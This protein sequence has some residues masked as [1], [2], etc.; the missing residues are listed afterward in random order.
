MATTEMRIPTIPM[1]SAPPEIPAKAV[2]FLGD[3]Y[4]TRAEAVAMLKGWEKRFQ[5]K[6]KEAE[7]VDGFRG[8]TDQAEACATVL[9]LVSKHDPAKAEGPL[10]L[11]AL[12]EKERE[13][14]QQA[15]E[16]D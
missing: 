8:A 13:A 2:A 1:E 12:V 4:F 15:R 14:L 7:D 6:A 10:D 5:R 16:G 3:V 11:G 9:G